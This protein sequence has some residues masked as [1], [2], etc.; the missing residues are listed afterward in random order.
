MCELVLII[1]FNDG[2]LSYFSS[3]TSPST[4]VSARLNLYLK[5]MRC[6]KRGLRAPGLKGHVLWYQRT[7]AIWYSF[8]N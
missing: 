2:I 6:R 7:T 1:K 8:K 5:G 4:Q 3:D